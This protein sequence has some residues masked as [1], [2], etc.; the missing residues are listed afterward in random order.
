VFVRIG[1]E[2][3]TPPQSCGLLNGCLR[4][5]MLANGLCK[6]R[7]LGIRDLENGE[8]WLGNSLR[9]LIGAYPARPA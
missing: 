5:E 6:E 2:L 4:R 7:V 8:V 3:F 1:G 9:G